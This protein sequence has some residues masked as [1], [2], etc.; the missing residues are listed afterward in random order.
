MIKSNNK[1]KSKNKLVNNYKKMILTLNQ[2][3]ENKNNNNNLKKMK[4]N[5]KKKIQEKISIKNNN[6]QEKNVSINN[7]H[8]KKYTKNS[9]P[10]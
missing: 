6:H 5:K 1:D 10:K 9:D 3:T 7:A 4:K 2:M 8:P